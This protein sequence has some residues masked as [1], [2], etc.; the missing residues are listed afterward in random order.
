MIHT[1]IIF[2]NKYSLVKA[3][4]CEQQGTAASHIFLLFDQKEKKIKK[5]SG[6]V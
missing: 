2:W 5:N 1:G 3:S 6:V 4:G